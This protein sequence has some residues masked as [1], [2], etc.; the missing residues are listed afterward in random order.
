MKLSR[1]SSACFTGHRELPDSLSPEYRELVKSADIELK[2]AYA[3]GARDFYTGG[4][5]GFDQ[6]A[7]ELVLRL[8]K[9]DPTVQLHILLPYEGYVGKQSTE[10][11]LQRNA[12]FKEADELAPQFSHYFKGCFLLRDRALVEKADICIA[13]L[14]KSP[15]GTAWTVSFARQK[16]IPVVL[17]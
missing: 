9:I 12:L 16:G 5:S 14:R 6:I 4:A 15:S 17:L 7:G 8:K 11:R 2:N 1:I 3:A 10:E 13:Y